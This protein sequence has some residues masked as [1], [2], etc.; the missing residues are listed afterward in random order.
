MFYTVYKTTNLVN[1]KIYV[2]LHVTKDLNDEYLG[3]GKQIQAAVKKYGRDNFKREYIKICATPEEMYNLEAEIVNEEFV[4][5]TDT[6]NMKT[7]GIGGWDHYHGSEKHILASKKG[8]R[9]SAKLLNEFIAKQKSTNSEWWQKWYDKVCKTNKELT[10][11]AQSLKAKAKRKDTFRK[12]NHQAGA[13]NSQFG[14]IWIS[15]IVTKEVKRITINDPIPDG[16]AR[17]KKGHL[18]KECW[19]NNGVKEHFIN[20]SKKQEYLDQGFTAGRLKT[21]VPQ[22]RIVV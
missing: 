10:V 12:I 18:I 14:R 7:G 13:A 8:G 6:Y 19:V 9:K 16:W 22:K 5:R 2:G 1:G 11:R 20:L 17:G 21:S 4:K 3:S 15:N